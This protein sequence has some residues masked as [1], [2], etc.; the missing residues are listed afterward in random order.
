MNR[1]CEKKKNSGNVYARVSLYIQ[2]NGQWRY[3]LRIV[4]E[5]IGS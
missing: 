3:G 4:I 2:R 1:L 5:K